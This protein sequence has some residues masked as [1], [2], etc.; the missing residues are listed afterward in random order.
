V[1]NAWARRNEITSR[2]QPRK[3]GPAGGTKFRL[4]FHRYRTWA[5]PRRER[6]GS[7]RSLGVCLGQLTGAGRPARSYRE[8]RPR[9]VLPI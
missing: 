8:P 1:K 4:A 5:P 6:I 9:F 2:K 3:T 7:M